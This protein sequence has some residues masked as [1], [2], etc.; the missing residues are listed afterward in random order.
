MTM[1]HSPTGAKFSDRHSRQIP[2]PAADDRQQ[3]GV[4]VADGNAGRGAMHDKFETQRP[5]HN[6]LIKRDFIF[7]SASLDI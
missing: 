7:Y 2:Q 1:A 4:S 3:H 5:C 6:A